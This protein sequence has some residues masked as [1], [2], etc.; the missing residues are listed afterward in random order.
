MT[1]LEYKPIQGR[2]VLIAY[3]SFKTGLSFQMV[4][5][6]LAQEQKRARESGNYIFVTRRT[7]LG[8]WHQHK[9]RMYAQ[10]EY[11]NQALPEI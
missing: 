8:R 2:A 11:F 7:V 4:R 3:E 10:Y 1:A 5:I 6:E 9:R